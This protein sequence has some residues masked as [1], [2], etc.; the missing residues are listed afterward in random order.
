M[1]NE[2]NPQSEHEVGTGDYVYILDIYNL[3]GQDISDS[4]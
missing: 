2:I 3:E 4:G 1:D